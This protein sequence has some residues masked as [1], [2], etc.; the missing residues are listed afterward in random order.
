MTTLILGFPHDVHIHA[1]RWALDQVGADYHV[2]YTP[3]LPH[4]LRASV[5]M[6]ADRPP[7]ATFCNR[8]IRGLTGLYDTVWYR[9][10]GHAMRPPGMQE[11]DWTVAA[12]ECDHHIRT[13]RRTCARRLLDQRHR[14]A[15]TRTAKVATAR[16]GECLRLRHSRYSAQQ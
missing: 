16:R 8:A 15:R 4:S 10:S 6:S 7:T 3:D 2:L 11:A 12:R 5:R 13:L 14:G 9:R 1:A